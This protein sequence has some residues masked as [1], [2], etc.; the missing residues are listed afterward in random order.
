MCTLCITTVYFAVNHMC[1]L[2]RTTCCLAANH[3]CAAGI[4]IELA[5][6]SS[7]TMR[8]DSDYY[9]NE[10]DAEDGG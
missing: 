9:N 4:S 3:M 7:M 10:G 1:T 6:T 8:M 5:A 2:L